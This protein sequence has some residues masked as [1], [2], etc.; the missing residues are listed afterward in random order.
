MI[1]L[2]IIMVAFKITFNFHLIM[3]NKH[4]IY[5]LLMKMVSLFHIIKI[6]NYMFN[7]MKL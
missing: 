3:Q 1:Y 2:L 6:S 4:L 5:S 7:L